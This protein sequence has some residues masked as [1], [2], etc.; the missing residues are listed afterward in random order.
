LVDVI[1]YGT[2]YETLSSAKDLSK[3]PT[4]SAWF[5]T[6][7][8]NEKFTAGIEHVKEQVIQVKKRGGVRK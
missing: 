5:S 7:S 4:L 3:Y 2:L 8:K 6:V 1:Y